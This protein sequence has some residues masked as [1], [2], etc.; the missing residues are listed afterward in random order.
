[1]PHLAPATMQPN[2]TE[3]AK[4]LPAFRAKIVAALNVSPAPM[5]STTTSGGKA[6]EVTVTD[7][8]FLLAAAP[9]SPQ[10]QITA[11][12]KTKCDSGLL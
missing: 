9:C 6:G 1:M 7:P 4:S 10:G 12:L 11:P 5:V 2:V 8:S 3:S